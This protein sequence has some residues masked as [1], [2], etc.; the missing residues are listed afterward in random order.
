MW[1]K[2][3]KIREYTQITASRILVSF[4]TEVYSILEL[5]NVSEPKHLNMSSILFLS[6]VSCVSECNWSR[7]FREVYISTHTGSTATLYSPPPSSNPPFVRRGRQVANKSLSMSRT[8]HTSSLSDSDYTFFSLSL[9]GMQHNISNY[10]W[11]VEMEGRQRERK[12]GFEAAIL[13]AKEKWVC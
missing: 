4:Q 8:T 5:E 6:S 3:Y 9:I 1:C 2:N 7:A 10:C 12:R 11:G 13:L